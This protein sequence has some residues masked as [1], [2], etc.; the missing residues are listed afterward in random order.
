MAPR[1]VNAIR[2]KMRPQERARFD[3]EARCV[4]PVWLPTDG[5]QSLA[6]KSAADV[7]GYGGAAG[8][9]KTDLALGLALTRHRKSAIF[10]REAT[11]VTGMIER[12]AEIMGDREGLN[13]GSRIWRLEGRQIEFGSAP[14]PGD[15][16]RY[17]GRAKDLLV[18]DEAANFLESQARFL[19]GWVRTAVPGQKCTTLLT[20]NPP[21]SA[22]GRWVIP[23]FAP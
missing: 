18:L 21:A 23:F 7:I 8:G 13:A 3:A 6:Y 12:L 14:H 10:R 16:T 11:Q 22:E 9:G 2:R 5:A 20:F 17:Q 4:Q 15:E 1:N 19:M